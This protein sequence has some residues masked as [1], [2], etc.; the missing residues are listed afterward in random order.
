MR[1][2]LEAKINR[3]I[4]QRLNPEPE[5]MDLDNFADYRIAKKNDNTLTIRHHGCKDRFVEEIKLEPPFKETNLKW[6]MLR[7]TV[8]YQEVHRGET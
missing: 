3:L 8:H 4:L 7:A 5:P 2:E 1:P 6:L